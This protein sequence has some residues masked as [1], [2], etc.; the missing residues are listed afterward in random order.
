VDR[1]LG[2]LG[3]SSR[4]GTN[5]SV[6][7]GRGDLSGRS[8]DDNLVIV[9]LLLQAVVGVRSGRASVVDARRVCCRLLLMVGH[10]RVP[11]REGTR[12]SRRF[13]AAGECGTRHPAAPT[14]K[15]GSEA[16]PGLV[17]YTDCLILWD[18]DPGR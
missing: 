10:V 1:W 13:T 14:K 15:P 12:T 5:T 11:R 17:Q 18:V 2:Y 9:V 8:W 4:D 7:V 16:T 6:D 3:A